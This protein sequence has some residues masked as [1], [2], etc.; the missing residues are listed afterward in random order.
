[1]D[2]IRILYL[3]AYY[4]SFTLAF[5]L[6][7]AGT[8][9]PTS[10]NRKWNNFKKCLPLVI[11][12]ILKCFTT[13]MINYEVE[14]S[15]YGVHWN[16]F[17][18]LAIIQLFCGSLTCTI[19]NRRNLLL[20]ISLFIAVGYELWLKRTGMYQKIFNLQDIQRMQSGLDGFV[21][22]NIEGIV[23]L[24]GYSALFLIGTSLKDTIY[25]L[26][27]KKNW[28]MASGCTMVFWTLFVVSVNEGYLILP[29]R[30]LCN[31]SYIIWMV[32]YNLTLILLYAGI[33]IFT[34]K[35]YRTVANIGCWA[36]GNKLL[37]ITF[38]Y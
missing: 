4:L 13:K 35:Y 15:E 19:G 36:I 7:S 3:V 12:G 17:I 32:A 23:S 10:N 2:Y 29:S 20:F 8:V 27:Q 16:F 9:S 33:E 6:Y 22:A 18:T 26:V 24:F 14:V 28:K 21:V 31:I 30:R 1:V 37:G 25:G 34:G 5:F 11:L 38:F